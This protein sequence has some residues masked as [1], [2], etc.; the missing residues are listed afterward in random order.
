MKTRSCAVN[1]E[2]TRCPTGQPRNIQRVPAGFRTAKLART[3]INRPPLNLICRRIYCI[4]PD[5]LL[6]NL[7]QALGAIAANIDATCLGID[8]VRI[9]ELDVN[10]DLVP[11]S[12]NNH[13]RAICGVDDR[14]IPRV[15]KVGIVRG[16]NIYDTPKEVFGFSEACGALRL[17]ITHLFVRHP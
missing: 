2:A 12:W 15:R 10:A 1:F 11:F 7:Q 14:F 4:W 3:L 6:G 5:R 16:D 8:G 17:Y 9:R 13:A